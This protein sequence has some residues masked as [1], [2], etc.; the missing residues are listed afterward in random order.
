MFAV[1]LV[2]VRQNL[3]EPMSLAG[4]CLLI[5]Q[6]RMMENREF[7]STAVTA[8][9]SHIPHVG[10]SFARLTPLDRYGFHTGRQLYPA[11]RS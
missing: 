11:S 4:R 3:F 1:T 8:K 6:A 2:L 10:G 5:C 9:G 7:L